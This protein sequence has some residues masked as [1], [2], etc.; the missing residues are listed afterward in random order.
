LIH[1]F[2]LDLEE[3]RKV[4]IEHYLFSP[5]REDSIFDSAR[6]GVFHAA[7]LRSIADIKNL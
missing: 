7:K 4:A 6:K 1:C 2:C 3:F 5:N